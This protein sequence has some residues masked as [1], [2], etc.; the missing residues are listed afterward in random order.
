LALT[1]KERRL[2]NTDLKFKPKLS[3]RSREI[4]MNTCN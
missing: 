2:H 4:G 3:G 1:M